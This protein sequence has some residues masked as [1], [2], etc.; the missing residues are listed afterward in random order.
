[1][2]YGS[3][4]YRVKSG[5]GGARPKVYEGP[6]CGTDLRNFEKPE[7]KYRVFELGAR[8]SRV[9]SATF[10]RCS[11]FYHHGHLWHAGEWRQSRRG[12]RPLSGIVV[13]RSVKCSDSCAG[14]LQGNTGRGVLVGTNGCG[15]S[16]LVRE[17]L[18]HFS[19]NAFLIG[20]QLRFGR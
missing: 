8:H 15:C 6:I 13:H 16:P 20:R 10:L 5:K 19:F 3:A 14:D 11:T 17:C 4:N 18:A 9:G 7:L 12:K 1:M 2:I